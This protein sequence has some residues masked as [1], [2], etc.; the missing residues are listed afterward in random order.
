MD[1]D[2]ISAPRT[3]KSPTLTPSR[4]PLAPIAVAR[5]P[6]SLP[7]SMPDMMDDNDEDDNEKQ[8]HSGPDTLLAPQP[9]KIASSPLQAEPILSTTEE[10]R[11]ALQTNAAVAV[12]TLPTQI[13]DE[14]SAVEL[15]KDRILSQ[16]SVLGTPS[17]EQSSSRTGLA[18]GEASA[19]TS[20][21]ADTL[22][23]LCIVAATS[24]APPSS[25][26][27]RET[28]PVATA[29]SPVSPSA[30]SR[31]IQV[32][33]QTTPRA[34]RTLVLG[35]SPT[36]TNVE[37]S[38]FTP[39]LT[40]TPGGGPRFERDPS[41]SPLSDLA[42]SPVK[43]PRSRVVRSG[44]WMPHSFELVVEVPTA[45]QKSPRSGS[46][47]PEQTEQT[48]KSG[49]VPGATK[50]VSR[51][52][53]RR[54][55][56]AGARAESSSPS[57]A[58]RTRSNLTNPA[59]SPS[60]SSLSSSSSSEEED[61]EED[62]MAALARAR[63]RVNAGEALFTPQNGPHPSTAPTT[64]SPELEKHDEHDDFVRRSTR[65]RR[66]T[67]HYSPTTAATGSARTSAVQADNELSS[68]VKNDGD[69]QFERM[70]NRLNAQGGK[71]RNWYEEKKQLLAKSDDELDLSD[72]GDDLEDL[73][74]QVAGQL[75]TLAYGIAGG[76]SDDELGS[77]NKR[78]CFEQARAVNVIMQD[79]ASSRARAALAG[80]TTES[81][82]NRTIWTNSQ[83][84]E[85]FD[86]EALTGQGW[87]GRVASAIKDGLKK[88]EIFSSSI[89]LFSTSHS[90][91]PEDYLTAAKWLVTLSCHPST[92]LTM[93]DKLEHL[94][95]RTARQL[96]QMHQLAGVPLVTADVFVDCLIT[97]GADPRKLAEGGNTNCAVD[98]EPVAP[99][100]DVD[101]DDE[102]LMELD[103]PTATPPRVS[104]RPS[105]F[106][107]VE[108]RQTAVA[109]WSRLVQIATSPR[110]CILERDAVDRLSEVCM[111]LCLDP[112]SAVS[113]APV[114]RTLQSLL[115][116]P[117]VTNGNDIHSA[118]FRRLAL[119][120]RS[121]SPR[122]QIEAVRCLP[123]QRS[124][125]KVLRKWIAWA[126]LAEDE[127]FSTALAN[128]DSLK[129]S[130]L[131]LLLDLVEKP[132]PSS[133]FN[134]P[135]HT[136]DDSNDIKLFQQATLLVI[137]FT[138]LDAELNY[139][140]NQEQA[141]ATLD[142]ILFRVKKLDQKLRS[143]ARQ[144]LHVARLQA[145]NLLTS[146]SNSLDYQLRRARGQEA[147]FDITSVG[148]D[149]E[150]EGDDED[151][152]Q[153]KKIKLDSEQ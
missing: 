150:P 29:S 72:D 16:T 96:A 70:M 41:G 130:L 65:A 36:R 151:R 54:T 62:V 94:F 140:S 143:D 76:V 117:F 93:I 71:G 59:T 113:Q 85:A 28:A 90:A 147:G 106:F 13:D 105:H 121:S 79:E 61:E 9:P 60:S 104:K 25:T 57:R 127:A 144:G 38:L 49:T 107:T 78:A 35:N 7:G 73:G 87:L 81:R 95:H 2:P 142:E 37:R 51:T 43:K 103:L 138:D 1:L 24:P 131:P 141:Q 111:K 129:K 149:G 66:V 31:S 152:H 50:N 32:D 136:A 109:R 30:A 48:S 56:L 55:A 119:L 67:E 42:P 21:S 116:C 99:E 20:I 3:S 39:D 82:Q 128:P 89:T 124:A 17:P 44:T 135:E 120:H 137:A 146:I 8:I 33:G 125:D 139:G 5:T 34:G 58:R 40:R 98:S 100:L 122:L 68:E 10:T 83:R 110:S 18:R 6:T 22:P 75:N 53:E 126:Y 118:V 14:V 4:R 19:S 63:A 97:L 46:I 91:A 12:S 64:A 102:D 15:P 132:P 148:R 86:V 153:A 134:P 133:A 11:F 77:P 52:G 112:T 88:P 26:A 92:P 45:R 101:S 47:R 123:H 69:R 115:H 23:R 84:C 108:S 74:A 80:E 114:V 27:D 145:K